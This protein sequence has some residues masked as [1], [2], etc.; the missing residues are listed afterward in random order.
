MVAGR[1]ISAIVRAFS[2]HLR[3]VPGPLSRN[4][5]PA[6]QLVKALAQ[7]LPALKH[8]AAGRPHVDYRAV[9]ALAAPLFLNSSIQAVLNL[10]DTWFLGHIS[11]DAMAAVGAV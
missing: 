1:C 11:T 8:D 9:F 7:P 6:P 10:T 3:C 4:V 2:R 5:D